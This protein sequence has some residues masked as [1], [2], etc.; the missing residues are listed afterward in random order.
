MSVVTIVPLT[1][2]QP[3]GSLLYKVPPITK[4]AKRFSPSP[5]NFSSPPINPFCGGGAGLW[6]AGSAA[7]DKG[8]SQVASRRQNTPA[9]ARPPI[10]LETLRV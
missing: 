8:G 4:L 7:S 5:I 6:L 2:L 9:H 1:S 10:A 3:R